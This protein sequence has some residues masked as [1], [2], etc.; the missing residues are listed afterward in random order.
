[1]PVVTL[2]GCEHLGDPVVQ[3]RRDLRPRRRFHP[4]VERCDLV[5]PET[6]GRLCG[7]GIRVGSHGPDGGR[8]QKVDAAHLVEVD[9]IVIAPF[10]GVE[11]LAVDPTCSGAVALDLHVLPEGFRPDSASLVEQFNHLVQ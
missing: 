10:G 6:S 11:R 2:A 5:F 3:E 9:Q 1:M 8:R 7:A 4:A